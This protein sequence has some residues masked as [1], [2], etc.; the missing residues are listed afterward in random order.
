MRILITGAGG[1]LGG[2]LLEALRARGRSAVV[3][4][5]KRPGPGLLRADLRRPKE[6]LAALRR[7]RPDAVFHLAGG[8]HAA[9]PKLWEAHV[10]STYGLLEALRSL[11][12]RSRPRVVLAGSA[13]EHAPKDAYGWSKLCQSQLALAYVPMGVEVVVARLSNLVGPGLPERHA[14]SSFCRQA[15]LIEAGRLSELSARGSLASGRDFV[16]VRDA[17]RALLAL[18]RKGE[19]G[20][21]Y[22]VCSGR[23]TRVSEALRLLQG[24]AKRPLAVRAKAPCAP[25]DRMRVSPAALRKRTGWKPR[26]TL[27]ESLRALLDDWRG[28]IGS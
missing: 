23:T 11:P 13:H 24:L 15:A 18:A 28:R 27:R 6:A 14:L 9:W 1:F 22:D 5:D 25:A 12:P 21:A 8:T 20:T 17:C 2:S 26:F 19:P 7:A 16:D 10:L 3:G 4:L